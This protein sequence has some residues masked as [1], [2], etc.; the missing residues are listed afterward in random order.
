MIRRPPRSTRTDTLFPYTTLCRS[1]APPGARAGRS[2]RRS[3]SELRDQR[4]MVGR[5]F[6]AARRLDDAVRARVLAK[7][8]GRPPLVETAAAV[9]RLPHL[10]AIA[11]PGVEWLR[12]GDEVAAEVEPLRGLPPLPQPRDSTG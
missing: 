1:H 6:P 2:R 11:P 3:K 12:R 8:G 7:V 9:R 5:P 4:N 10:C